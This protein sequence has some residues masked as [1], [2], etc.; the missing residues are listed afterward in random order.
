MHICMYKYM[1][2]HGQLNGQLIY[3]CRRKQLP[4]WANSCMQL[5]RTHGHLKPW[6]LLRRTETPHL[7]WEHALAGEPPNL[8]LAPSG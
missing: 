3:K 7:C 4:Q 6:T 8:F 2:I 1:Y 5:Q